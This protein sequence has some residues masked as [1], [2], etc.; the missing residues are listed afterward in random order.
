MT[1]TGQ[2]PWLSS[3]IKGIAVLLTAEI[4]GKVLFGLAALAA[5]VAMVYFG[6]R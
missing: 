2:D 1:P 3:L 4:L 5:F 6:S